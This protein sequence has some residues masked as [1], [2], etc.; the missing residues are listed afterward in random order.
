M[1]SVNWQCNRPRADA[2]FK[3]GGVIGAAMSQNLQ[4]CA[5]REL[6]EGVYAQLR[7]VAARHLARE[8]RDHTLGP[9]ALVHEA[10]MR[11][12]RAGSLGGLGKADLVC[13]ASAAMRHVLVDHARKRRAHKRGGG[14]ARVALDAAVEAYDRSA[15]GLI[16]LE[17]ALQSLEEK[18]PELAR[19]VNLRFFGGLTEIE[20]AAEL[21]ISERTV[22]RG[23]AFARQW[24]AAEL[25]RTD[26]GL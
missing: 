22:R 21:G 15:S 16:E 11:L 2:N 4:Q 3:W 9:T 8:R 26:D 12:T 10:Y 14:C 13:M 24:L 7:E 25:R 5:D 1:G 17:S 19:I 6:E 20:V 18:E 23:W